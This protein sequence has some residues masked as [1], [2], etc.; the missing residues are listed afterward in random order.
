MNMVKFSIASVLK[1]LRSDSGIS[2]TAMAKI[3]GC[4]PTT[5]L[6]LERKGSEKSSVG[7]IY[8]VAKYFN[9][10]VEDIMEQADDRR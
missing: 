6:Y 1:K 5:I 2:M 4:S 9:T 8:K 3:I 10:T 7:M